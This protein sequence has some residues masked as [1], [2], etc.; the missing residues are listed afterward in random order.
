MVA[1]E[2]GKER[3]WEFWKQGKQVEWYCQEGKDEEDYLQW[4]KWRNQRG[5]LLIYTRQTHLNDLTL[6]LGYRTI[7]KMHMNVDLYILSI[8]H[9][10]VM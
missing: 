10:E 2:G 1:E 9:V 3:G 6:T 5:L 4:Q 7:G 8:E